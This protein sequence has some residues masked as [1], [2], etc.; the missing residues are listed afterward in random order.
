MLL[1]T[2]GDHELMETAQELGHTGGFKGRSEHLCRRLRGLRPQQ[3]WLCLHVG[4]GIPRAQGLLSARHQ[5]AAMREQ[6][7]ELSVRTPGGCRK[8]SHGGPQP[9][10]QSARPLQG[11]WTERLWLHVGYMDATQG[12]LLHLC[13]GPQCFS[14]TDV[15]ALSA[16]GQ[17][18]V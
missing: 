3:F 9:G 1:E 6:G 4:I 5:G 13:L 11:L 16:L 15:V 17:K 14:H 12:L 8:A 10:A 2:Y 7:I 18:Q